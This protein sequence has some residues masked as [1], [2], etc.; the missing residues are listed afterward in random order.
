[1]INIKQR[2]DIWFRRFTFWLKCIVI[3][4]SVTLA[5]QIAQFQELYVIALERDKESLT[6]REPKFIIGPSTLLDHLV[7]QNNQQ[8]SLQEIESSSLSPWQE[9]Q[10]TN[11]W[12]R[13]RWLI[14]QPQAKI[15]KER[16]H[17]YPAIP[18][19][20]NALIYASLGATVAAFLIFLVALMLKSLKKLILLPF[21]YFKKR[22]SNKTFDDL[23]RI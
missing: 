9:Y 2:L 17:F 6:V 18:F 5:L 8:Q 21:T 12:M 22:S 11:W 13:P 20:Q 23:D 3:V 4:S 16:S 19:T 14:H 1:V 7:S 15:L 10:N